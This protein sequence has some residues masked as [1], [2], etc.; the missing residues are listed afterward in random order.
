MSRW[1][2]KA[3]INDQNQPVMVSK[4]R[5]IGKSEKRWRSRFISSER[6]IAAEHFAKSDG[7]GDEDG[8]KLME[9]ELHRLL[10][11]TLKV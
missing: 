8:S 4:P 3:V 10:A 9:S 2:A 11:L 7:V 5:Q 1:F 6:C